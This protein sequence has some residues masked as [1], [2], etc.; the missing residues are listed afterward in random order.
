MTRSVFTVAILGVLAVGCVGPAPDEGTVRAEITT[1]TLA[2]NNTTYSPAQPIVVTWTGLS[3]SAHDWVAI[4][5]SGSDPTTI[6]RWVYTNGEANGMSVFAGLPTPGDYVARAFAD[7]SY[8]LVVESAAFSII[9]G[10]GGVSTDQPSYAIGAP[11]TITWSGL[12]GNANDWVA[13]AP[14][15]S[16]VTTVTSYVYT[17]GAAGGS[18][19]F[20]GPGTPGNYVVRTFLDDSYSMVAEAPF[21]ITGVSVTSDRATYPSGGSVVVTWSGLP[22]NAHDWVSIAPQESSVTTITSWFYTAGVASGTHTFATPAVDGIYVARAYANDSYTI[23]GTSAPFTTGVGVTVDKS[24]YMVDEPIDVTWTRLPGNAHDWIAIAPEGSSPLTI[25]SWIYTGG[26]VSDHHV[27]PGA[28]V[29]GSYVARAF[30][31]DSY[32]IYA[33]TPAFAVTA[34]PAP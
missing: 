3:A 31:D 6:S 11:V 10:V 12:P 24:S 28:G 27:F 20:S 14:A 9:G 18:H 21:I 19:V 34:P 33:E 5:P 25:T 1:P 15:G 8:R 17:G 2:T 29:A 23:S 7:D 22:G 4:A 32:A 13:L 26:A 30:A 16:D